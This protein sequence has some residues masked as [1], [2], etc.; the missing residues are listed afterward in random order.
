MFI[1]G[2]PIV[3]LDKVYLEPESTYIEFLDCTRLDGSKELVSRKDPNNFESVDKDI[4][5][6]S[7]TLKNKS[8]NEIVLADDVVF[9]GNVLKSIIDKFNSNGISVLGIRSCISMR[10][11]YEYFNDV[12]PLGL[13]CGCVM[14]DDVIDQICERDFYFGIPQS[15]ISINTSDGVVKAPYFRPFGD[16][17]ARASIPNVFEDYFSKGCLIRSLALWDRINTLSSREVLV[18]DLPETIVNTNS[19]DS[20]VKTLKKE[21]NINRDT[22]NIG[23]S[24]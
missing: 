18:R 8:F 1:G 15:G 14:E 7:N 9:S 23:F 19:N 20:V 3:S 11:S 13:K 12:L 10:E 16:P 6:I 24:R 21:I 22:R 4:E 5:R 17:V 2:I